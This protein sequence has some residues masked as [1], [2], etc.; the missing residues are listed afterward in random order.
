MVRVS[1]RVR[2]RVRVRAFFQVN[3]PRQVVRVQHHITKC[4]C[5]RS[6][7]EDMVS[8]DRR[9]SSNFSDES[10]VTVSR[11]SLVYE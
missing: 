11:N 1:V 6:D 7:N 8:V 2:V 9:L 3:E 4:K 10:D 5:I